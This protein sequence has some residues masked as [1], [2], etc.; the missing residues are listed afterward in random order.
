[1]IRSDLRPLWAGLEIGVPGLGAGC[2]T[3]RPLSL[4]PCFLVLRLLLCL[5]GPGTLC[6]TSSAGSDLGCCDQGDRRAL[7]GWHD[8]KL[9]AFLILVSDT[10]PS[11]YCMSSPI[12]CFQS[13]PTGI[14]RSPSAVSPRGPFITWWLV[15]GL[16][17]LLLAHV[18]PQVWHDGF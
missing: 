3:G 6:R 5:L 9:G 11:H 7:L 10:C 15:A 2:R 4:Q 13:G 1:M 12:M 18:Q 16:E 14:P 17:F 8:T